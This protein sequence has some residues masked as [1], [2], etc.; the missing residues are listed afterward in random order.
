MK[1]AVIAALCA[2]AVMAACDPAGAP[3]KSIKFYKKEGCKEADLDPPEDDAAKTF[4]K[5]MVDG[6]N[7]S[8]KDTTT[9]KACDAGC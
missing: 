2:S 4:V 1:Y 6:I 5:T 8:I 7:K 9:C 3:V